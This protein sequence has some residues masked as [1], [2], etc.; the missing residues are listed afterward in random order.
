MSGFDLGPA[1]YTAGDQFQRERHTLFKTSWLPFSASAQMPMPGDFVSHSIGGWPLLAVRGDDGVA[2]AFHNVCQ[3]Q[4]MPVVSQAA[5][6]CERLRCSY[7][8]WSYGRQGEFLTAP[9]RFAPGGPPEQFGLQAAETVESGGIC[10]ARI[11]AGNAPPAAFG[12]AGSPLVDTLTTDIEAN[13]KAVVESL[14]GTPDWRFVWPLAFLA[15][16]TEGSVVRQ[17]VPR[18]FLRTRIVD[19]IFAAGGAFD[20]AHRR[21][22]A[23]EKAAA[24]ACQARRAAGDVT[25]SGDA[26]GSFLAKVAKACA[27]T[28]DC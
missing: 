15:E 11:A 26:V 14:L 13:W 20:E 3:H 2:R 28:T 17:I 1:A 24:E 5:G 12:L 21:R 23:A 27:E 9:E 8:G 10:Q 22:V 6:N 18:T 19:L 4:R 7:H 16:A 25:V